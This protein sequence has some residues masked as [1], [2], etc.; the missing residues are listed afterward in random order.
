MWSSELEIDEYIT[1]FVCLG[2]K[3]YAYKTNK[4]QGVCKIKGFTLNYQTSLLLNFDTMSELLINDAD[5]V[6]VRNDRKI[7]L[8]KNTSI[9]YNKPE[10]KKYRAVFTKR[11][12]TECLG[13]RPFGF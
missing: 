9:I 8:Q 5:T 4:G 12:L 11:Q 10:I 6:P 13:S 3:N 2:A 1:D 7:S